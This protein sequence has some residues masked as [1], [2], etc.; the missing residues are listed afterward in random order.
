M[1]SGATI[2]EIDN[3]FWE[4]GDEWVDP[5]TQ[6]HIDVMFRNV[7]WIEEQLDRVLNKHQASIG[8][9]TCMWHNVLYSALIYDRSG[10]FAAP[11]HQAEQPY[12]EELQRAI[13]AKNYP[14]L[15]GNLSSYLHQIATAVDRQDFVSLNHRVTALLAS[16]FDILFALNRLPH[17]GEKRLVQIAQERCHQQHT[18]LSAQVNGLICAANSENLHSAIDRVNELVDELDRLLDR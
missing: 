9:S 11:Q 18:A 16:Y 3:Q 17:P 4:P 12:P 10:W 14:L 1:M 5:D 2:R 6:I 8:Y 7:N 13:I 15:R